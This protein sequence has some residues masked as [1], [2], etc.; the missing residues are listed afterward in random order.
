MPCLTDVG[1]YQINRL[2]TAR[3]VLLA[4]VEIDHA[5][6]FARGISS[7]MRLMISKVSIRKSFGGNGTRPASRFRQARIPVGTKHQ[8]G[9]PTP[10]CRSG[11][12]ASDD[13]A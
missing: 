5:G 4:V 8:R 3:E 6:A 1:L 9:R 12:G 7:G 13:Q 10:G 2:A 11:T